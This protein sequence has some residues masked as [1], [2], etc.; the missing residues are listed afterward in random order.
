M[1]TISTLQPQQATAGQRS[2][3]ALD[4]LKSLQAKAGK[5]YA[6]AVVE[7]HVAY[8]DLAAL[9]AAVANL[10]TSPEPMRS[11]GPHLADNLGVFAHPAF[12]PLVSNPQWTSEIA[13]ARDAY[14]TANF[15]T[16]A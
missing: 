8:V 11:F 3:V 1:T 10:D 16:G 9:D 12:A 14:I 2:A 7:L 15:M 6:S 4:E 5:R 13:A